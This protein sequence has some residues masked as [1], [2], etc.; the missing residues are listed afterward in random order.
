MIKIMANKKTTVLF[1]KSINISPG[2]NNH[3]SFYS[4]KC[5]SL[6]LK[7]K[8]TLLYHKIFSG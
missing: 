3:T 4:L 8:D 1:R 6:Y 5:K 7:V 2:I